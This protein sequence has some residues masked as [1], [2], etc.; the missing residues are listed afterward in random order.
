MTTTA[1]S[2]V[3]A[4]AIEVWPE[5]TLRA[6]CELL[7]ENAIGAALVRGSEGGVAGVASERDVVRAM[8]DGADP[9]V[10]RVGDYMT[11]D[12]EFAAASADVSALA[13]MMIVD[14]I[15]H[16]PVENADGRVVGVLSIRDVLGALAPARR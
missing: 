10:D 2:L 1:G 15:R 3:V 7:E 12:V 8:A 11:F 13:E 6:F 5:T 4:P 9:D 14:G 16:L